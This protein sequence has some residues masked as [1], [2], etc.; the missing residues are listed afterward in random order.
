MLELEKQD[1][2]FVEKG[3]GSELWIENNEEFCGKILYFKKGKKLSSHYHV[4]KKEVFYLRSGKLLIKYSYHNEQDKMKELILE[5]G[6]KFRVPRGLRH[7]MIA[8][9]DSE[10]F[11]FSTQHFDY[12]S[13][14]IVKGD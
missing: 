9:E 12:D 2:R 4:E 10:L 7:Q 11:E 13:Y 8:L 1:F 5:P 14:R 3:W 6:M